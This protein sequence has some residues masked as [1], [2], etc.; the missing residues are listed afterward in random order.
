MHMATIS[1]EEITTHVQHTPP[2]NAPGLLVDLTCWLR[3]I[4]YV[5]P[6][7]SIRTVPD[8]LAPPY[9]QS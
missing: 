6:K 3:R 7:N 8:C 5:S 2:A 9:A 4:H 1:P